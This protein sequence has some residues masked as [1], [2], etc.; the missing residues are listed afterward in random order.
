MTCT[1][2]WHTQVASNN[3]NLRRS[4]YAPQ[5]L[6]PPLH[7][8]NHL[9]ATARISV[10]ERLDVS[11][12]CL[13]WIWEEKILRS[14]HDSRLAISRKNCSAKNAT[15]CMSRFNRTLTYLSTRKI[16]LG[17]APH[18]NTCVH[19]STGTTRDMHS[20]IHLTSNKKKRTCK[21]LVHQ[22]G[23]PSAEGPSTHRN[24]PLHINDHHS[25]HC[26]DFCL[27]TS[28][29]RIYICFWKIKQS[30]IM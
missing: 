3:T 16:L 14:Q 18:T 27:R 24:A 28:R 5:T 17:H 25:R 12:A 8:N 20:F 15:M 4:V 21:P 11:S 26:T 7:I 1:T 13:K 29:S 9:R 6:D 22:R 30:Y 10:L 23:V 19:Q 2:R